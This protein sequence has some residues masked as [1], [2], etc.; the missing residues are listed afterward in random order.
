MKS[1]DQKCHL[2][3]SSKMSILSGSYI[4]VQLF[5][6]NCMEKDIY[7]AVSVRLLNLNTGA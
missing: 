7:I 5:H 6:S 1:S 3:F 4:Y 2:K